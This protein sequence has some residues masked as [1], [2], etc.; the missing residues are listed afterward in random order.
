M[1]VD[2]TRG[3]IDRESGLSEKRGSERVSER[4]LDAGN[5][6]V[7]GFQVLPPVAIETIYNARFVHPCRMTPA[8]LL[9]RM[10]E[11]CSFA[12]GA[13]TTARKKKFQRISTMLVC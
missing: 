3:W 4:Y 8:T 13:S 10:A 1:D 11:D 12:V 2:S 9:L 5:E 6:R 7:R